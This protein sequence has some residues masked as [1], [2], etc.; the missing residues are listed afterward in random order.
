M[1]TMTYLE[2][3]VKR[4]RERERVL[5]KNNEL[6]HARTQKRERETRMRRRSRLKKCPFESIDP[7]DLCTPQEC[8]VMWSRD[9]RDRF[10]EREKKSAEEISNTLH[11]R[12]YG[13]W[14][15]VCTSFTVL[16]CRIILNKNCTTEKLFRETLLFPR[17][18]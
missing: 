5:G 7:H 18:S 10:K 17:C 3:S 11:I 12:I 1:G 13:D 6:A 16:L 9:M 4:E 8:D 15:R 2:L 14:F